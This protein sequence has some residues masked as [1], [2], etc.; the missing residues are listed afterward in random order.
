[1]L[2]F[3]IR[4]GGVR[5]RARQRPQAGTSAHIGPRPFLLSMLPAPEFLR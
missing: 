3:F 5:V 1:M 4:N 2:G